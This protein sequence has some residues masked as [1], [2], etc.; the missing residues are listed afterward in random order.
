MQFLIDLLQ[1]CATFEKPAAN[2][3]CRTGTEQK[4]STVH[5]RGG[6]IVAAYDDA[7]DNAAAAAAAT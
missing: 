7:A 2:D 1:S 3:V 6:R 4:S 5:D